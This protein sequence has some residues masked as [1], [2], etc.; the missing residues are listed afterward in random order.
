[1][2]HS[3]KAKPL[4]HQTFAAFLRIAWFEV[5]FEAAVCE[6]R[7]PGSKGQPSL[8]ASAE[9]GTCLQRLHCRGCVGAGGLCEGYLGTSGTK[10]KDMKA[11]VG[12]PA[13]FLSSVC[14]Y[15]L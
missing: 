2:V 8:M 15:Y 13:G 6:G 3:T 12:H 4:L 9:A 11:S 7:A 5:D 1:M 14:S 10:R